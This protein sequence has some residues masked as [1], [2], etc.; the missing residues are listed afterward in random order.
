MLPPE[1]I[2]IN[3]LE[4]MDPDKDM[5]LQADAIDKV[6]SMANLALAEYGVQL[7]NNVSFD[8][9]QQALDNKDDE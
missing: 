6:L 1:Q 7:V 3:T 5:G 2:P 9:F 8:A 4:C